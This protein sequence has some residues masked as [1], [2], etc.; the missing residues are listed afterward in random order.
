M[1][2]ANRTVQVNGV[3]T[4]VSAPTLAGVIAELGIESRLSVAVALDGAVVPRRAWDA[5]PVA[6][7]QALEI[8]TARQ[9]G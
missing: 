8:V 5:T 6:T 9:G 3:P 7:G 4:D 2:R 1:T